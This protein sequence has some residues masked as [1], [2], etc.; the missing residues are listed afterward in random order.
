VGRPST[1]ESRVR[2]KRIAA[3]ILSEVKAEK[4][5]KEA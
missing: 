5:A 1:V 3:R 2:S 4:E